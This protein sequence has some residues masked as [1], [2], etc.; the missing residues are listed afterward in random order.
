MPR[1]S[2]KGYIR[3]SLVSVPVEGYTASAAGE[4]Q[5]ALNQLHDECHSRIRYKK[6][7][8]E[9][10][11]VPNDQ[12]VMGYQ[13]EKDQYIVID[14]DEI[15]QLRSERDYSINVD[16]FV[17]PETI[18]ATYFAGKSYYLLPNGRAGEKPYA[19]LNRAMTEE[20]V[21]G[22]AQVVISN[23]EQLVALRT[24]GKLLAISALQ[25]A[26]NVRTPE[27]Y[28][29][30][31]GNGEVSN[32][33]LKLARMLIDATREDEPQLEEYHDLYNERLKELVESKVE[34]REI[35]TIRAG[36]P[37][38][39]INFIDAI[40]ESLKQT[41]KPKKKMAVRV[42]ARRPQPKKKRKTA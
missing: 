11:E 31:L 20:R 3:L 13:F 14:P 12:I 7:C 15:Q 35:R 33:E 17:E 6:M 10:G 32:E 39:A 27:E 1:A 42:H 22:L 34:G 9:H 4:T 41:I 18:D 26:A 29:K 24:I 19:L 16:R 28:E 5:I 36:A 23:R 8:E 30:M 25:Y 21:Y 37:P 38:P 2:W 40:R